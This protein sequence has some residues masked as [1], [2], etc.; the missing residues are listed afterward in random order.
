M[1]ALLARASDDDERWRTLDKPVLLLV[2]G[3]NREGMEPPALR[4]AAHLPQATVRVLEGQG[5][6]VYREA[7]DLLAAVVGSWVQTLTPDD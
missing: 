7:P 5:H 3:D 6:R 2:S 4:L 1:G